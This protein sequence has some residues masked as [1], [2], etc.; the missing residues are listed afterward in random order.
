MHA[1]YLRKSSGDFAGS[2]RIFPSLAMDHGFVSC[3]STGRIA[4]ESMAIRRIARRSLLCEAALSAFSD[5]AVV[6]PRT[7]VLRLDLLKNYPC[8]A[9]LEL[10]RA[11]KRC[12]LE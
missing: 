6:T 11:A 2:N 1:A 3:L 8:S 10:S 4:S 9:T 12:R 5:S 7:G